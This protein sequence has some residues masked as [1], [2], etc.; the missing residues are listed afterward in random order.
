MQSIWR[1]HQDQCRRLFPHSRFCA[2]LEYLFGV[3]T[4]T[5]ISN[6]TT[7]QVFADLLRSENQRGPLGGFQRARGVDAFLGY[8]RKQRAD[9]Q[10][11]FPQFGEA[12]SGSSFVIQRIESPLNFFHNPTMSQAQRNMLD[13]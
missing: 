10:A 9:S 11:A 6:D 12:R 8:L 4:V 1:L 7:A 2:R 5:S 13:E 3:L